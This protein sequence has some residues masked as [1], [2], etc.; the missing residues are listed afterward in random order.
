MFTFKHLT[1]E[2]WIAENPEVEQEI[3]VC[4]DCGGSGVDECPCCGHEIDCERCDGS[5]HIV[6]ARR[7]YREQLENDKRAIKKFM[8]GL[9]A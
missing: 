1:Y 3:V 5:G 2:E 4:P 8:K 7:L 6:D 9:T